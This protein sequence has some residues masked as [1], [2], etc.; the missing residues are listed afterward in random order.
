MHWPSFCH[1]RIGAAVESK[2]SPNSKGV[3]VTGWWQQ[4]F[5]IFTAT[6]WRQSVDEFVKVSAQGIDE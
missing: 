3:P 5:P 1:G 6:G 2:D 4:G